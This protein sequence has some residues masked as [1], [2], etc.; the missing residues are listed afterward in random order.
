MT[1]YF[2]RVETQLVQRAEALYPASADGSLSLDGRVRDVRPPLGRRAETAALDLA[3]GSRDSLRRT[4]DALVGMVLGAV[5]GLVAALIMLLGASPATPDF[6]VSRGKGRLV[7]ISAAT[8]SSVAALNNRLA[9]LGIPIRAANVRSD[10]VAPVQPI[11]PRSTKPRT[12]DLAGMPLVVRRL[13]GDHR[14][15]LSVRV[16]PPS[17]AGQTLVLAAG[18][19]GADPVGELITGS[20]PACIRGPRRGHALLGAL[21]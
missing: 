11:G 8:P 20:P 21:S 3:G 6:S 7:T 4:P 16:A 5:G 2:D 13:K 17:R 14:A 1:D 12:L 18:G 9:S 15:L 19:S 10:C